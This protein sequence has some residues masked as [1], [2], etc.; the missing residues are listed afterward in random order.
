MASTLL[1]KSLKRE[2][3]KINEIYF[4]SFSDIRTVYNVYF[5]V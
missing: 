5:S 4:L 1:N 2:T 3:P